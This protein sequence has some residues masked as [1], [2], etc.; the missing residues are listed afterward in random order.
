MSEVQRPSNNKPDSSGKQS[1][2]DA[3]KTQPLDTAELDILL[4]SIN[5]G[6]DPTLGSNHVQ[7]YVKPGQGSSGENKE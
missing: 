4:D 6:D 3:G 2:F 5:E 1:E 7:R